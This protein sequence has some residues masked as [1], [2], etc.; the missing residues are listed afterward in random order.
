MLFTE[1]RQAV[2]IDGV[3]VSTYEYPTSK[4][5]DEARSS[6]SRDGYSVQTSTAEGSTVVEWVATPH[7]Y[8]AGT[9]LV[10]YVG[11]EQRTLDALQ[12]LLGPP[13]AGG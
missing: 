10:L 13:F 5:L 12:R 2:L 8:S 7:F 6:I 11:D 1:D 4:A 3:S 9:L